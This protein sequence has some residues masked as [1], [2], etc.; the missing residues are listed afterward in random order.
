MSS[1]PFVPSNTFLS[2]WCF[3]FV[4]CF[5]FCFLFCYICYLRNQN[6]PMRGCI[7]KLGHG[8]AINE[9]GLWIRKDDF[10]K[11]LKVSHRRIIL[12]KIHLPTLINI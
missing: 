11:Y 6:Q 2:L 4:F 9:F 1:G 12:K 5:C 8:N 7:P 3:C 10:I